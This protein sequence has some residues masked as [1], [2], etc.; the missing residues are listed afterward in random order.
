M[1][2]C[3][4]QGRERRAGVTIETVEGSLG[5]ERNERVKGK[6]EYM[7][8]IGTALGSVNMQSAQLR[9]V[10]EFKYLGCTMQSDG[11]MSTE[12]NKRKRYGWNN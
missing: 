9:Q 11:D 6:A 3:C 8:L 1:M 4:A 7:C 5:D 10:T 2:W 12:I